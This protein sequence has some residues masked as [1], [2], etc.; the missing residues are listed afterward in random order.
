MQ[1]NHSQAKNNRPAGSRATYLSYTSGFV[2]SVIWTLL[3]YFIITSDLLSGGWALAAVAGLAV[4]QLVTQLVFFIH[5]GRGADSRWNVASFFF[6]LIVLIVILG[7]SLWIMQNLSNNL[8]SPEEMNTY[9][10]G[11]TDKGF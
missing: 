10:R 7:G 8:M 6:M 2:L 9:M 5:L 4:V 11:Q 3:A 1:H